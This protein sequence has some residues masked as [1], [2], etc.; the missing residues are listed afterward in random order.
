MN[1]PLQIDLRGILR[2]R[3]PQRY[4][5]VVPGFIYS[6][7]E[8]IICQKQLNAMLRHAFPNRG[9]KFSECIMEH[10]GITLKVEGLD[11]IPDGRHVFASNHP[12]GGLD[13]IVLIALLGKK[14][15]DERIRFIVNDLL[16]NVEPLRDV[17]LPV[18]KFGSQARDVA[19]VIDESYASDLQIAIFPAG[20]VSR[21][22]ADGSIADL[23]WQKGFV[24]KAIKHGRDIVPVHFVALNRRRFYRIARLR[25]RLGLK[26]NIE[27]VLLPSEVC[28]TRNVEFRIIF[29]SP[30]NPAE[31]QKNGMPPAQ[32]ADKLRTAVYT[33]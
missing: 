20:L 5:R 19:R 9:S 2:S 14:Y 18:N 31:M 13:G 3:L 16:M 24:S 33:L 26:V 17:F 27:Q 21:M 32:I 12:L 15:G 30:L 23:E 25:K 29:G 7:L 4:R 8:R 10:L 1:G 11:N 6:L 28:N 22:G